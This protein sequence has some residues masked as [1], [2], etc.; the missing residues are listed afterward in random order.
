MQDILIA[1]AADGMILARAVETEDGQVL[2]GKG[3]V[4]TGTLIARLLKMEISHVQVEGRPVKI[5]GEKSLKDELKDIERR[6]SKVNHIA[7]LA[8]LKKKI[9][10]KK[11]E[12]RKNP[13]LTDH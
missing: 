10:L 2:C 13:A 8:Y 6:F 11:I 12:S 5:V 1:Q 9:M 7:P 3:T 4:L